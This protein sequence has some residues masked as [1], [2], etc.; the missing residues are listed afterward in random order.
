MP[1]RTRVPFV[2]SP[3]GVRV[4]VRLTPRGGTDRIE[5]VL[6]GADGRAQLKARVAA[7]AEGGKANA[8][9]V[10]LLAETAGV[11]P[12]CVSLVGG[13]KNRVKTLLIAGDAAR[14][15]DRLSRTTEETS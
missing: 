1:W 4:R 9:L 13:A 3:D 7:P 12:S 5:G 8:A 15:L 2:A 10:R 11:A 14:I 6:F